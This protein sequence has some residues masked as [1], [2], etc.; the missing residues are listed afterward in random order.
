MPFLNN[1]GV[2]EL[3]INYDGEEALPGI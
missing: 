2:K 1:I 3:Y